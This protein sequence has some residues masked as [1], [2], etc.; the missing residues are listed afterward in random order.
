MAD[1]GAPCVIRSPRLAMVSRA[2]V[3]SKQC[4]RGRLRWAAMCILV[5]IVGFVNS[6]PSVDKA[7][8]Q[9]TEVR[10]AIFP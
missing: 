4:N 5:V 2:M 9:M 3:L 1:P 7:V 6:S 10:T 8:D